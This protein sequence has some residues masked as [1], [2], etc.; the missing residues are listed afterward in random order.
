MATEAVVYPIS[1]GQSG[2]AYVDLDLS[3][4]NQYGFTKWRGVVLANY[5]GGIA[6]II[7]A[8]DDLT[9]TPALNPFTMDYFDF[10]NARGAMRAHWLNTGTTPPGGAQIVATFSDDPAV[11]F[12]GKVYPSALPVG[13]QSTAATIPTLLG[14]PIGFSFGS[15]PGI[16]T[17]SV[18]NGAFLALA[19]NYGPAAGGAPLVPSTP[20]GAMTEQVNTTLDD[21]F[22]AWWYLGNVSGGSSYSITLGVVGTAPDNISGVL[23]MLSGAGAVSTGPMESGSAG[24][25]GAPSITIPS[26]AMALSM[27]AVPVTGSPKSDFAPPGGLWAAT[28]AFGPGGFDGS[29]FSAS[30]ANAAATLSTP[31]L[32]T[33]TGGGNTGP[34]DADWQGLTM[35]IQGA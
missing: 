15:F 17:E 8:G 28:Q 9:N 31:C 19:Y 25:A 32:W 12:A 5:S 23:Y 22:Q 21:G 11:D 4:P 6:Q 7:G 20:D 14:P 26:D 35:M 13:T 2:V 33:N 1:G 27:V 18:P 10:T 30:Q 3:P 29:C 24:P 34:F 16:I